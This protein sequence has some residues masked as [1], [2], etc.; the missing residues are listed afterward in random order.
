MLEEWG[1]FRAQVIEMEIRRDNPMLQS[2]R[3][4]NYTRQSGCAFAMAD[5][6]LDRPDEQL[7]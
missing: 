2:Q 4:A 5:Y 3:R 1:N 6:C 7:F